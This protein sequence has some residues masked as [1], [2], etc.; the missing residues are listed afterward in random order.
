MGSRGKSSLLIVMAEGAGSSD[1]LASYLQDSLSVPVRVSKLG[2]IQRGGSPTVD[3]RL[4]ASVFGYE[5]VRTIKNRK[6]RVML[7]WHR[8]RL[9]KIPLSYPAENKK[10]IDRNLLKIAKILSG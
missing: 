6:G 2:Y 8:D 9:R 3:S 7:S 4:L 1:E 10:E 5:A